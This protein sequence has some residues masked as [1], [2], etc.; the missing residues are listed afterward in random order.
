MKDPAFLFYSSDFLTGTMLM[1]NEEIGSYIRLLC[2]QHQ[3]G[4]LNKKDMIDICNS[5][6]RVMRKFKEDS[7]GCYY[8]LRLE[9]ETLKRQ[10]YSE[11]RRN[12]RLKSLETKEKEDKTVKK[13]MIDICNSYDEHMENENENE[14]IIVNI[15]DNLIKNVDIKKI[16]EYLNLKTNSNFKHT[17]QKTKSLISARIKEGFKEE[18]FYKVIDTKTSEWLNDKKMNIYLKP[19]TLFSPKFEGYLNQKPKK[20]TTSDLNIDISDVM[21]GIL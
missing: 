18:D 15:N 11:S 4:H 13:D 2:L 21:K 7:S 1:T 5:S 14:N 16:I 20:M 17:T 19:E 8:N 3:Q 10:K 6:D 12:N 9:E